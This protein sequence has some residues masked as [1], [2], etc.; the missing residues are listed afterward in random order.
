MTEGGMSRITGGGITLIQ[1][2]CIRNHTFL[3]ITKKQTIFILIYHKISIIV[4]LF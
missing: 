3:Q 1:K 4:T 2:D